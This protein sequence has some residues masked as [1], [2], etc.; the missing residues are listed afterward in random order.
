M[1]VYVGQADQPFSYDTALLLA[2]HSEID[3]ETQISSHL[4][5]YQTAIEGVSYAKRSCRIAD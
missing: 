3:C 4:I 2:N 5:R 1:V